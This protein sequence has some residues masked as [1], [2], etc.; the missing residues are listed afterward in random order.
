MESCFP[1]RA[2]PW[3]FRLG[4]LDGPSY[5]KMWYACCLRYPDV[6]LPILFFF[7]PEDSGKSLFFEAFGFLVTDFPHL[8]RLISS[9][10]CGRAT[11]SGT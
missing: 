2:N 4:I 8:R 11:N 10:F 7:G 9:H 3:A 1:I 6:P 5:L